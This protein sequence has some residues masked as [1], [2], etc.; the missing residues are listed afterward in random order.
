M[1]NW[2]RNLLK[3]TSLSTALFIFQACYGMPQGYADLQLDLEIVDGDTLEPISNAG[4][5]MKE[6]SAAEWTNAGNTD[7]NGA[8]L[9][10]PRDC[11]S[12]DLRFEAEG[13]QPK[14]TTIEDLSYRLITI[15]LY[16][17]Q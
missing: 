16:R 17:K 10:F 8:A 11:N 3:C 15:K 14:D 4:I 1:K 5:A 13:F 7:E 6:D 12:V 2:A 9:L